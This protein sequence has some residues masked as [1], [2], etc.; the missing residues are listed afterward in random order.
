MGPSGGGKA[1]GWEMAQKTICARW[2]T[3][4][5]SSISVADLLRF[6][7]LAIQNARR[8]LPQIRHSSST[9]RPK[10]MGWNGSSPG[11]FGQL[12]LVLNAGQRRQTVILHS[13]EFLY[14]TPSVS[15]RFLELANFDQVFNRFSIA[16]EFL[17]CLKQRRSASF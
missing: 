13:T 15:W 9:Q 17:A 12:T 1:C 6:L 2:K 14:P 11:E 4:H 16:T 7:L 5:S 3:Q 10:K 8:V